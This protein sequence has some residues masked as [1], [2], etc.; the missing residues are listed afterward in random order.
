MTEAVL[1]QVGGG[2]VSL[3]STC[4]LEF[5]FVEIRSF[6]N[7]SSCCC[8][9]N[10]AFSLVCKLPILKNIR[11]HNIGGLSERGIHLFADYRNQKRIVQEEGVTAKVRRT[12]QESILCFCCEILL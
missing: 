5:Y 8:S 11:T 10:P 2:R 1:I 3:S 12:V 6:W 7:K 9:D 4:C